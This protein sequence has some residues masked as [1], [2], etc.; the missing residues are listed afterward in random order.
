MNKIYRRLI[1]LFLAIVLLTGCSAQNN[2]SS[3]NLKTQITYE[4]I[5]EFMNALGEH[6]PNQVDYSEMKY[7]RPDV[8]ELTKHVADVQE[9]LEK[10]SIDDVKKCLDIS[11]DDFSNFVTMNQIAEVHNYHDL[12]DEFYIN[13]SNWLGETAPIVDQLKDELY[14]SVGGS[15]FGKDL[16]SEYFWEGFCDE[17]ANPDDSYFNEKTVALMQKEN[18]LI[19]EY[20]LLMADPK[21]TY[22]GKEE[23]FNVLIDSIE[24]SQEY[25][26]VLMLFY[27]KYN[28]PAAELMIELVK[29]RNDLAKEMGFKNYEE[30]Q[31]QYEYVRD[32]TPEDVSVLDADIKEHLA[33]L[34]REAIYSGKYLEIETYDMPVDE[35]YGIIKN[36]M[37]NMNDITKESFEF[38]DKY[39]LYDIEIDPYKANT[40]FQTYFNDYD[41]PFLFMDSMGTSYDLM[42]FAHEF[43]HFTEAYVNFNFDESVDLAECY[44]QALEYLTLFHLESVCDSEMVKNI[45]TN[46]LLDTLGV[47]VEESAR[48]EFEKELYSTPVEELSAEKINEIF[49]RKM[50]EYQISDAFTTEIH[51]YGWMEV[52]HLFEAPFYVI[53]YPVSCHVAFQIYVLE[54]E[55]SGAGLNTFL[56]ILPRESTNLLDVIEVG[57]LQSPFEK[58]SVKKLAEIIEKDIED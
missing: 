49:G 16:E 42:T 15:K 28:E 41:S 19:N 40:S 25:V 44:S 29:T 36:V 21:I 51:K 55:N 57:N 22:K 31:Y 11:F 35:T 3:N 10:D 52:P 9:A 30:M 26:D 50:E 56:N 18:D 46:K 53:S 20:H 34:Y 8:D 2:Q 33:P 1:S 17:Y 47:F 13:E 23:S 12:R 14:F 37:T 38:M 4:N 5:S 39:H 7:E 45:R 32:F 24:D 43:G 6:N 48:N 54:S 58:G 27:E